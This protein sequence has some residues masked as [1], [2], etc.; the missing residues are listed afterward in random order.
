MPKIEVTTYSEAYVV[1]LKL[2]TRGMANKIP[3]LWKKSG[4]RRAEIKDL[5][6][7]A[8]V[9]YGISIMMPDFER[10]KKYD[11]IAGFP[12]MGKPDELPKGME[13]F[14]IPAGEYVMVVCPNMA[15]IPQSYKAI[16]NRWLPQSDYE[17]DLSNGNFCF[18][19][20]GE[21]FDPGSGSGKFF[22][23]VPIRKK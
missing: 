9:A 5:D 14:K 8:P 22:I 7:S 4:Q 17:L 16:Y 20:Y 11:Y 21:E 19:L 12:V 10:T 15:S 13:F 23:Y 1:G 18:E 2:K 3:K 6:E